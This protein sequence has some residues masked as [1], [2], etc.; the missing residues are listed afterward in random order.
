MFQ[1][2]NWFHCCSFA[3]FDN[4]QISH[5]CDKITSFGPDEMFL[6]FNE[7]GS[8]M[9]DPGGCMQWKVLAFSKNILCDQ[10]YI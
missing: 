9:L 7:H 4:S 10:P 5:R 6:F 2:R 1:N 8:Y 3:Q